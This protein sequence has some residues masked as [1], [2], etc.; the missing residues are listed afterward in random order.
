[1]FCDISSL[2]QG[3]KRYYHLV[4]LWQLVLC[5]SIATS[6]EQGFSQQNFNKNIKR[7]PPTFANLGLC[8]AYITITR[9]LFRLG[10]ILLKGENCF[11]KGK[12]KSELS[13][14]WFLQVCWTCDILYS[15]IFTFCVT[16][17][18]LLIFIKLNSRLIKNCT[19]FETLRRH[20]IGS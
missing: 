9:S 6:C 13:K 5:I 4:Q 10:F 11:A 16:M 3:W 18:W 19:H 8:N 15:N 7:C 20:K 1:M 2:A 12:K 17:L 14:M